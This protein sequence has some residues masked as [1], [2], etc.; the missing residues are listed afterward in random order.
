MAESVTSD[1]YIGCWSSRL[2]LSEPAAFINRYGEQTL[3]ALD[4][5][6]SE[7]LRSSG[8]AVCRKAEGAQIWAPSRSSK[9]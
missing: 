6:V 2:P 3:A 5:G 7:E 9:C 8:D 4:A 1:A